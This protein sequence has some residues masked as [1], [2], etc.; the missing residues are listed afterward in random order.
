M[1]AIALPTTSAN[2]GDRTRAIGRACQYAKVPVG[3]TLVGGLTGTGACA[4][5][6]ELI[7]STSAT[8]IEFARRPLKLDA[9]VELGLSL[10]RPAADENLVRRALDEIKS[11]SRLTWDQIAD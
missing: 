9:L 3:F 8:V 2:Y 11:R 6:P 5:P 1:S 7:N 10:V 4:F